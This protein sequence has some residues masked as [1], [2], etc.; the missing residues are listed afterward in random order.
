MPQYHIE[1]Q[2]EEVESFSNFGIMQKNKLIN[3]NSENY[4]CHRKRN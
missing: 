1:S 4:Q 3:K 2:I